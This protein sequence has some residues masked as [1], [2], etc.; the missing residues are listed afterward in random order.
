M[1]D[2]TDARLERGEM[3]IEMVADEENENSA[4]CGEDEAGWMISLASRAGEK[5]GNGAAEERSD[6]AEHDCPHEAHVHVQY[7]L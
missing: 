2:L 1:N 4:E 7:G 3:N 5:V 6:D